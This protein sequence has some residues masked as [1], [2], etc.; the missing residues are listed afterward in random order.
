M[1]ASRIRSPY[2]GFEI[3][4]E[5]V[6]DPTPAFWTK[7]KPEFEIQF[8]NS[9]DAK[10]EWSDDCSIR[11]GVDV[12]GERVWT[13]SVDFGP[14]GYGES[15]STR[16]T[17][18]PLTLEG[19]GVLGVANS[20]VSDLRSDRPSTMSEARGNVSL[21]PIYTFG[22][23]DRSKYE[24]TIKRPK[25]LQGAIILTSVVLIFFAAVQIWLAL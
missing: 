8:T 13:D 3:T 15:D 6:D 12:D 16:V 24:A 20:G 1:P 25:Q 22:V 14:I 23:L 10:C 9:E 18:E 21:H 2:D 11:V 19:H 4:A 17:A 5:P 7:S